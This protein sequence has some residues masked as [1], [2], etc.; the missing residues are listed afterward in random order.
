MALATTERPVH[1]PAL[2]AVGPPE[3]APSPDRVVVINDVSV[4]RGGATRVALGSIDLLE[5]AGVPTTFV[6]GDGGG[7]A[8]GHPSG[9]TLALGGRHLLD[10][11]LLR[12]AASGLYN[13]RAAAKLAA[14]IAENDTPRTVY[15]LHGWSKVLSPAVFHALR[16][17]Q[18]R[19]VLSAH[20]YFLVC[21]NGAYYDYRGSSVC[22]RTPLGIAC[23]TTG[24]DRRSQLH[25][26]WRSSRQAILR[27]VADLRRVGAV[28]AVHDGMIPDLIRGGVPAE[29]I[30][31]LRNPVVPWSASRVEA[32]RNSL[33]LYVGRVEEEK[34]VDLLAAAARDAGVRLAVVGRGALQ[35]RLAHEYPE[36][37]QLG[38]K[39]PE[40]LAVLIHSARAVVM[41]SRY[42]E[43]FG[44]VAVEAAASGLPLVV[45]A[46]AAIAD[47]IAGSGLGLAADPRDR[48]GFAAV[49]TG[50]AA[51]DALVATMSRRGHAEAMRLAHTPASW[52]TELLTIYGSVLE[53]SRP[54]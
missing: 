28:L 12:N 3:R 40:E 41:P 48:A 50:L 35:P 1:A 54:P 42:P 7:P 22:H 51:D 26:L 36:V 9:D 47:E 15:H 29:R 33:F 31:A 34:G 19:L 53:R 20:D 11:S 43:P 49:L 44:L 23:L 32:E 8:S 24:C 16:P 27:R 39:T 18:R 5:A 6:A 25:K 21:P 52:V 14:W 46:T 4:A 13:A 30:R 2:E 38:W 45:S 17:V 37:R 10:G